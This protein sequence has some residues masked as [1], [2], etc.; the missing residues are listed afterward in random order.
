M[1]RTRETRRKGRSPPRIYGI[2]SPEFLG[3]VLQ[4]AKILDIDV[5]DILKTLEIK[6]EGITEEYWKFGG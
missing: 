1:P 2:Y 3:C 4:T 6:Y 5:I